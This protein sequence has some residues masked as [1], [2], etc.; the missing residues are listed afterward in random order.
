M[1]NSLCR[2]TPSTSQSYRSFHVPSKRHYHFDQDISSAPQLQTNIEHIFYKYIEEQ[3]EKWEHKSQIKLVNLQRQA[4]MEFVRKKVNKVYP[5]RLGEDS[6]SY[7]Q[8]ISS[9]TMNHSYPELFESTFLGSHFS[10]QAELMSELEQRLNTINF[11]DN[12]TAFDVDSLMSVV[13]QLIK[14]ELPVRLL[15]RRLS[16]VQG[17]IIS[18]KREVASTVN[19]IFKFGK[20]GMVH[21]A[22]Q[23]GAI[24]LDWDL[25]SLI[26][27]HFNYCDIVA[28]LDINSLQMEQNS[29]IWN[30]FAT[31]KDYSRRLFNII[32][33]GYF[34]EHINKTKLKIIAE[35]CTAWNRT[36][37]YDPISRNCQHFVDE[38]LTA[39][40]FDPKILHRSSCGRFFKKYTIGQV[41]NVMES[42]YF[43]KSFST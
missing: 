33:F 43:H 23:V 34:I 28:S 38:L 36:K 40:N 20:Y 14:E 3:T 42:A 2:P 27:P 29:M 1:G 26:S 16:P 22:L 30:F 37:K 8:R 24:V 25:P 21:T 6:M 13:D 7:E 11:G 18:F 32:T 9:L 19:G 5:R 41:C 31:L 10:G 39:L 17:L 35:F 12:S 15:V 4:S